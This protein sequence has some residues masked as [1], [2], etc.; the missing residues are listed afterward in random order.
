LAHGRCHLK[1]K[2]ETIA[3]NEILERKGNR[4]MDV[5]KSIIRDP[6]FEQTSM[7]S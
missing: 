4:P 7:A 5:D 2:L 3:A 1:L 6:D